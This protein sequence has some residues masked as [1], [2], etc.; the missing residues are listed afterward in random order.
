MAYKIKSEKP[1]LNDV[2][3]IV[4]K[5][6]AKMTYT[7]PFGSDPVEFYFRILKSEE[8]NKSG[9][10]KFHVFSKTQYTPDQYDRY[11]IEDE[12]KLDEKAMAIEHKIEEI[13]KERSM[14]FNKLDVAFM[15]ASEESGYEAEEMKQ[16]VVDIKNYLRALPQNLMEHL[17]DLE[18]P[19]IVTFNVYNNVF[20][21]IIVEEGSGYTTP[22]TI[23]I[24]APNGRMDGFQM[25]AVAGIKDGKVNSIEVT[26]IGSGYA[27]VPE[28]TISSPDEP[29]GI[30]AKALASTPENDIFD[31]ISHLEQRT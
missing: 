16:H 2:I 12:Q 31:N 13:R 25:K 8:L 23:E 6:G 14:L 20:H 11:W 4:L 7:I 9:V 29:D 28:I 1:L 27:S 17:I 30:Q 15:M 3:M 26:Q 19:E 22:P 5:T 21:I 24:E 10:E 18:I